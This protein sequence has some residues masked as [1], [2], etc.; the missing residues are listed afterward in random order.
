MRSAS[1]GRGGKVGRVGA[2]NMLRPQSARRVQA[3][4]AT[5]M[6]PQSARRVQTPARKKMILVTI[7]PRHY[8]NRKCFTIRIEPN[9]TTLHLKWRIEK[10]IGWPTD[11]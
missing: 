9:A 1:R 8:H 11:Q 3:P 6:R 4:A 2:G 10:E 7:Q 5:P